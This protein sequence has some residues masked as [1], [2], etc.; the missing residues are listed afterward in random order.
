MD[1]FKPINDAF[2]HRVGDEVL[3]MVA[4]VISH[5]SRSFDIVGRWGGDE[6]LSIF[7]DVDRELLVSIAERHRV[8]VEKSHVRI[9]DEIMHM[10]ISGGATLARPDDTIETLIER[11]DELLYKS[12][13]S[14]R[15]TLTVD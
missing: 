6:F 9:G 12:K 8:L 3:K 10:T 2:G 7:A 15:N 13:Q 5:A 1:S 4:D 14:G 11:A